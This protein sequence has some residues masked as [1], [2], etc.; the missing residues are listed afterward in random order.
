[1][2]AFVKNGFM[3]LFFLV[4]TAVRG[5]DLLTD[6][7]PKRLVDAV[8]EVEKN[9]AD[10]TPKVA[11]AYRYR[12][13]ARSPS[14][15]SAVEAVVSLYIIGDYTAVDLEWW[16]SPHEDVRLLC[17][18]LTI[19]IDTGDIILNNHLTEFYSNASRFSVDESKKR[20]AEI[21][22]IVKNVKKYRELCAIVWREKEKY[23]LKRTESNKAKK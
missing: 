22:S 4:C 21:G 14:S 20:T 15:I 8:K 13:L 5:E 16:R 7:P 10:F 9:F 1:M 12:M 19:A 18:A 11:D 23:Q 17:C 3:I 6:G 2:H